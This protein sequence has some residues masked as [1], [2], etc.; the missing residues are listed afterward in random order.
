[1]HRELAGAGANVLF[2]QIILAF[3]PL[4]ST[5]V[6]LAWSTRTTPHSRRT[7]VELHAAI[8]DAVSARDPDRAE[9]AMRRHFDHSIVVS[10]ASRI[11]DPL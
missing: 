3:A 9:A 6:P 7:M 4:L 2:E 8:A 1:F 11:G 10:L 5:A